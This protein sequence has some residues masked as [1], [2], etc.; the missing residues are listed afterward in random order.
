ML[1]MFTGIV[2]KVG[3]ITKLAPS[4]VI[5]AK[6]FFKNKKSGD[7]ISVNGVCLTIKKHTKDKAE[8]DV[9]KETLAKTNLK[10]QHF[11]NLESALKVGDPLNGHIVQGHVDETGEITEIRKEKSQ[12]KLKI[13]YSSKNKKLLTAKGSIAVNGV[14]LTISNISKNYFEVCLVDYTLKNTNLSKIKEG[15]EVNLEF[16]IVAKYINQ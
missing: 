10:N 6:N 5:T 8:F 14:S 13:K 16:D 12:T 15:D 3:K 9:M 1:K 7:S 2:Q 11:I 4:L